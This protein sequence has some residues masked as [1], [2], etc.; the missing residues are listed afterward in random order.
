MSLKPSQWCCI[1]LSK[2][3]H[4]FPKYTLWSSIWSLKDSISYNDTI[5]Q[6]LWNCLEYRHLIGLPYPASNVCRFVSLFIVNIK[7]PGG[8]LKLQLIE[9]KIG[10]NVI[11][12]HWQLLT[13]Q[14]NVFSKK[15]FW[16]IFTL[17]YCPCRKWCRV[18]ISINLPQLLLIVWLCTSWAI[19]NIGF[20]N[21]IISS[22]IKTAKL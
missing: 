16:A 4:T 5:V 10:H 21:F 20:K 6:E 17:P 19:K 14:A 1:R 8:R 18:K 3:L 12:I 11:W 9:L 22:K 15:F 7:W 2:F 13:P